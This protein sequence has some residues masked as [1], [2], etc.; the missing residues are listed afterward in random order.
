V[1]QR[2]CFSSVVH[3]AAGNSRSAIT[4]SVG[5]SGRARSRASSAVSP[6]WQVRSA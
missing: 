6:G 2:Y 1:K 3:R 4:A 5:N